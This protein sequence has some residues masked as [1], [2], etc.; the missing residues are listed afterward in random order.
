VP[1]V[2]QVLTSAD[3]TLAYDYRLNGLVG[4]YQV[5]VLEAA[6]TELTATSFT[7]QIPAPRAA[8][9]DPRATFFRRERDHLRP[10]RLPGLHPG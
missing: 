7:D 8:P 2:D 1:G 10:G 6:G 4:P 5:R 9:S 3:G